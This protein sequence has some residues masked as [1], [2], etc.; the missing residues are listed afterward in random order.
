MLRSILFLV[1]NMVHRS[2]KNK[3]KIEIPKPTYSFKQTDDEPTWYDYFVQTLPDDDEV[4]A[5]DKVVGKGAFG[6]VY[7]KNGMMY[8]QIT[9]KQD[10]LNILQ[11]KVLYEDNMLDTKA[12]KYIEE[13]VLKNI[14]LCGLFQN[15]R[16]SEYRKYFMECAPD[17]SVSLYSDKLENKIYQR[18]AMPLVRG[19]TIFDVIDNNL[20]TQNKLLHLLIEIICVLIDCKK[21][22]LIHG[23]V[24]GG[25]IMVHIIDGVVKGFKFI[26]LDNAIQIDTVEE[27]F[28]NQFP[29]I[30]AYMFILKLR[31]KYKSSNPTLNQFFN[32]FKVPEKIVSKEQL[33]T[34]VNYR[35]YEDD[36]IA[37]LGNSIETKDEV[38]DHTITAKQYYKY[39]YNPFDRFS[40]LFHRLECINS[41][42]T[43]NTIKETVNNTTKLIR[44]K[45]EV[46]H[47]DIF[48]LNYVGMK[49]KYISKK[50]EM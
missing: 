16:D 4:I 9:V 24:H 28:V 23:D 42:L 1:N 5:G 13:K 41:S 19:S 29:L 45:C 10:F 49:Q 17:P 48:F 36:K 33:A 12:A 50:N 18:Y 20:I 34:Q 46:S 27:A 11:E 21:D 3:L 26:D 37:T 30:E 22:R 32:F 8:K 2:R 14:N 43:K 6:Q 35:T 44:N 15:N 25:N 47:E 40:G 38:I 31:L 7:E 39:D